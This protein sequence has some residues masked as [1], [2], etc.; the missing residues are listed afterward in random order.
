M[1]TPPSPLSTPLPWNLVTSA[2]VEDVVPHFSLFARDALAMA[3]VKPGEQ[4]LDVATGPGTLALEAAKIAQVSAIDFSESM[5]DALRSRLAREGA[6]VEARVGDGMALPY[7][8]ASFDAAFSMFGLIFFPDRLR[9]LRELVRV[10]RPGGRAVI[11]SWIPMDQIPLLAEL[12]VALQAELPGLPFSPGKAPLGERA[13]IVEELTAAGFRDVQVET[14]MH[15]VESPSMRE[16]FEVMRRSNAPLV[17]LKHKLGEERWAQ[18]SSGVLS[19]LRDRFGD[20]PQR[21]EFTA[22]LGRGTR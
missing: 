8:D 22:N 2:Y 1:S 19:R 5:I 11:S 18:V 20:G 7:P 3:G 16:L 12:F 15:P 13:E 6:Q 10:L 14:R 21:L 4:V 9:G 17:L